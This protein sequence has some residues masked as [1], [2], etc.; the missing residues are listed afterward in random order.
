MW[1]S[2]NL[3]NFVPYSRLKFL[4]PMSYLLNGRRSIMLK[5]NFRYLNSFISQR[6][7]NSTSKEDAERIARDFIRKC[8][9]TGKSTA[10]DVPADGLDGGGVL[11]AK[12]VPVFQVRINQITSNFYVFNRYPFSIAWSWTK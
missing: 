1:Q 9:R 6:N 12:A 10:S 11:P 3:F 7:F 8:T 4:G 2:K 5:V